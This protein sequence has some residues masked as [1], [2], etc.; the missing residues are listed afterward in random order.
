[1]KTLAYF[2]CGIEPMDFSSFRY[3]RIILIDYNLANPNT[4]LEEVIDG[5]NIIKMAC[6]AFVAIDLL[7][8]QKIKLDCF[9]SINEGLQEGGGFYPLNGSYFLSYLSPILNDTYIHIYAPKYYGETHFKPL[10]NKKK[11]VNYSFINVRKLS[12]DETGVIGTNLNNGK[13]FTL[14]SFLMK[15]IKNI[16]ISECS[17]HFKLIHGNI[18]DYTDF[19]DYLFIPNNRYTPFLPSSNKIALFDKGSFPFYLFD[20]LKTKGIQ[21]LGII[22]WYSKNYEEELKEI[23]GFAKKYGIVISLFFVDKND[24]ILFENLL[25][26]LNTKL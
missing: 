8:D 6:D 10:A 11:F 12:N 16:E 1:M 9:I 19:I 20:N 4:I 23:I 14:K 25:P 22:P 3:D 2:G 24:K 18:W 13:N 26:P 21:T 5:K 15:R 7:K 17:I